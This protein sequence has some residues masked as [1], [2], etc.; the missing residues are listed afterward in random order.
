[1]YRKIQYMNRIRIREHKRLHRISDNKRT[2]SSR[3]DRG[4]RHAV[5][6]QM[7][8]SIVVSIPRKRLALADGCGLLR[9][10]YI[11][12]NLQLQVEDRVAVMT[13]CIN[14]RV[15]N[16]LRVIGTRPFVVR[17]G[18]VLAH[19]YRAYTQFTL[20]CQTK[21][22]IGT[23]VPYIL[24]L[25]RSHLGFQGI[26]VHRVYIQRN[27]NCISVFDV[28]DRRFAIHIEPYIVRRI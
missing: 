21:R 15:K 19:R 12:H 8:P 28:C 23:L 22:R 24:Q 11:R 10:K 26:V 25:V 18:S 4:D 17:I 3:I 2:S 5:L 13:R 16:N 9:H 20:A 6:R 27:M 14:Q 7:I 1:M